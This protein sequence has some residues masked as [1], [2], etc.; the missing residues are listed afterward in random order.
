[1]LVLENVTI[2]HNTANQRSVLL[3]NVTIAVQP[4]EIFVIMGESGIGK[5][6]LLNYI[7]GILDTK[8]FTAQ[9]RIILNGIDITNFPIN[10]RNISMVFQENMLFPHMTIKQNLYFALP[11]GLSAG[12]KKQ[13]V[14]NA[15]ARAKITGLEQS[16]P[17]QISGGQKSRVSVLRS[18][19]A[20]PKCLLLDEPFSA[21]DLQ[22]RE[23]FRQFV[24]EQID[25]INIP[26]IIVTH[27][28]DDVP[29]EA[30]ILNIY[31]KEQ[32]NVR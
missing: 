25:K 14:D 5:T 6:T 4:K 13:R 10:K 20:N 12:E 28:Y 8:Q 18:L 22:L 19:L 26:V 9:G 2:A 29:P 15:V 16:Y 1:M 7:T 23:S 27:D 17:E 21:L 30:K 24:F 32:S 31:H 11:N 3:D